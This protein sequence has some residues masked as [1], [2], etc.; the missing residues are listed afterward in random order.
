VVKVRKVIGATL[1]T[2]SQGLNAGVPTQSQGFPPATPHGPR[3]FAPVVT[4]TFDDAAAAKQRAKHDQHG[5]GQSAYSAA[6]PGVELLDLALSMPDG[7][8][9]DGAEVLGEL[10]IVAQRG[11]AEELFASLYRWAEAIA[12]HGVIRVND[13]LRSLANVT[14]DGKAAVSA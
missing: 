10:R 2:Q 6:L 4:K 11:G 14:S 13:A 7:M 9:R 8:G 12:E 1:P 3:Y 5:A